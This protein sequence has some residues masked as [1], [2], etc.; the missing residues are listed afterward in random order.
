MKKET[1]VYTAG[2]FDGEGCI[3]ITRGPKRMVEVEYIIVSQLE[4]RSAIPTMT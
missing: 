4:W 1:I 2:L 3:V